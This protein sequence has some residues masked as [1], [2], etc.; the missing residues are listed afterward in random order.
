M[1]I[2]RLDRKGN[3]ILEKTT[4]NKKG[5]CQKFQRLC[6]LSSTNGHGNDMER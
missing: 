5:A 2:K 3:K 4:E 6:S 1:N